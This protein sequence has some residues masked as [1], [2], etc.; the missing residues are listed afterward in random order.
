MIQEWDG[1]IDL[2]VVKHCINLDIAAVLLPFYCARLTRLSSHLLCHPY[3]LLVD[4]LEA[5]VNAVALGLVQL[6]DFT[7]LYRLLK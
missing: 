4:M 5:A 3:N 6:F 7:Y 1:N 2:V